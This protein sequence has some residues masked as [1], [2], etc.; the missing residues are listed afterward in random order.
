MCTYTRCQAKGQCWSS[1]L[2]QL[3]VEE[4]RR[5]AP[6]LEVGGQDGGGGLYCCRVALGLLELYHPVLVLQVL[7]EA[8][9]PPGFTPLPRKSFTV[10]KGM[11]VGKG[12]REGARGGEVGGEGEGDNENQGAGF[13]EQLAMDN[14]SGCRQLERIIDT[15]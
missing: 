5:H 3:V 6:K 2:H 4:A 10:S 15:I 13:G 7:G 9:K 1:H 14:L 8:G 11:V 12:W